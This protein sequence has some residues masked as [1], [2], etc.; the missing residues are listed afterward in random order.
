[1][2]PF[3]VGT[4]DEV[5]YAARGS[6]DDWAYAIGRYPEIVTKCKNEHFK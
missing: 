3:R 1:M 4:M 5:I 6:F 2:K